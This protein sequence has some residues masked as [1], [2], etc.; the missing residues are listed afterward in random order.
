MKA[1]AEA[2]KVT[3][4]RLVLIFGGERIH[5]FCFPVADVKKLLNRSV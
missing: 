2:G 4:S 5:G 1:N 3:F